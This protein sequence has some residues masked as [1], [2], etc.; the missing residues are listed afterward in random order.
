M[1]KTKTLVEIKKIP[2]IYKLTLYFLIYS[3]IGWCLETFY[4]F[5]VFGHFVNRG[6]LFGPICPIY[7][8]GAI[9]LI[10]TLGKTKRSNFSKFLIGMIV[11]TI[12]EF[13]ASLILEKIFNQRW[14]DYTDYFINIQGRVCLVFSLIWGFIG[15]IF[16]NKIHPFVKAKSDRKL[17]YFPLKIKKLFILILLIIFI[18]DVIFSIIFHLI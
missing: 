14:W 16:I 2:N 15:V 9:L 17:Y 4:A 13:L 3:F 10:L 8:F 7:G 11:F 12:F 18:V 5:M 6:F 1:D